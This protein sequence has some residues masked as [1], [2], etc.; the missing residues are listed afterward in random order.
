M[1]LCRLC[2]TALQVI[3]T[4]ESLRSEYEIIFPSY[5][6]AQQSGCWICSKVIAW[7]EENQPEL[8]RKWRGSSL[9]ATFSVST[10]V[11]YYEPPSENVPLLPSSDAFENFGN[12]EDLAESPITGAG[13]DKSISRLL[14]LVK[15]WLERCTQEHVRCRLSSSAPWV[16]TR[17]LHLV[18]GERGMLVKMVVT[19]D[20][21]IDGQYMTLSHRWPVKPCRRLMLTAST[22]SQLQRGVNVRKLPQSFQE[23]VELASYLGIKYLWI[24]CLCIMQD[25]DDLSD[26]HREA[27]TMHMVY[28]H[29]FLNISATFSSTGLESLF[30]QAETF[31]ETWPSPIDINVRGTMR[32]VYAVDADVWNREITEAP[33][34]HRGWVFQERFLARRIVHFGRAQ[35]GWECCE[36]EALEMFPQR[37]PFSLVAGSGCKSTV[38]DKWTKPRVALN[39]DSLPNREFRRQLDLRSNLIEAYS[40]CQ[41]TFT[42]DRLVAF[43]GIAMSDTL[44]VDPSD[45]Y[46]AGMWRSSILYSLA[47]QR[48]HSRCPLLESAQEPVFKVPS[49]SWLSFDG[50]VIFPTLPS[51]A[52]L[53]PLARI[54]DISVIECSIQLECILLSLDLFW[55]TAGKIIGICVTELGLP[56]MS[57]GAS[58]N[59]EDP[60][61]VDD[62][63]GSVID[64]DEY[65]S[66]EK[67]QHLGLRAEAKNLFLVP[68]YASSHSLRGIFVTPS[69]KEKDTYIRLGAFETGYPSLV[70]QEMRAVGG[71]MM[72][73]LSG[74][75]KRTSSLFNYIQDCSRGYGRDSNH[76][77]IQLV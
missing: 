61:G 72:D 58:L 13:K 45:L 64:L 33:L 21:V 35:L 9:C 17:L 66:C 40:Q 49:W 26:W 4:D 52:A 14:K 68:L 73:P 55:S 36:T 1:A 3:L 10:G 12:V 38:V 27:P 25:R 37:V 76:P 51:S 32:K 54:V 30:H 22:F 15:F 31:A 75:D 16:P 42:K 77:V 70:G 47:W 20:A 46:I 41:F 50:E 65:S 67:D 28:S 59:D 11:G 48:S 62:N 74:V 8:Y 39:A 34:N 43:S 6:R 63:F 53:C 23:T 60:M 19:K 18:P 71:P 69:G 57:E 29:S 56:I 24:D 7:A 44:A 2:C 5:L